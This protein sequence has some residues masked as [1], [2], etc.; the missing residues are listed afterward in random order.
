MNWR[1]ISVRAAF[2]TERAA[3]RESKLLVYYRDTVNQKPYTITIPTID[4]QKLNFVPL[5]GDAV[6]F[7]GAAANSDIVAWVTSF[8]SIARAPDNDQ[9]A[10]EVTGMRYVG[11][12]T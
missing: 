1:I 7:S 5:A 3:Q 6:Q 8:E 11:R 10:V 2:P 4:F 12:N 9:H